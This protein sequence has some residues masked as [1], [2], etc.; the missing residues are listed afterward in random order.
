MI[1]CKSFGRLCGCPDL[2]EHSLLTDEIRTKFIFAG[3]NYLLRRFVSK[4]IT[5]ATQCNACLQLYKIFYGYLNNDI[6]L[7]N[8]VFLT[9]HCDCVCVFFLVLA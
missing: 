5:L 6:G 3:P 9:V 4:N 7:R 2:S 8:L 1:G